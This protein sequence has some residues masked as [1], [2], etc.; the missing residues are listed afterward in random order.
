MCYTIPTMTTFQMSA[1]NQSRPKRLHKMSR[2]Q[3][4]AMGLPSDSEAK[5]GSSDSSVSE[6]EE[7]EDSEQED[8]GPPT[9]NTS[10]VPLPTPTL[11]HFQSTISM[12]SQLSVSGSTAKVDNSDDKRSKFDEHFKTATSTDE[13]V[14]SQLF[15][16]Y[17]S[18]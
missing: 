6:P 8:E 11:L 4:H 17:C 3:R 15:L 14:L 13:E 10:Q 16:F 9:A 2:K 1:T 18:S 7:V 5:S 12:A